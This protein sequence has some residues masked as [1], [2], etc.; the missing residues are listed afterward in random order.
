MLS[1]GARR[2]D[3]DVRDAAGDVELGRHERAVRIRLREGE[4]ALV[5]DAAVRLDA[6]PG[7]E[8]EPQHDEDREHPPVAPRTARVGRRLVGEDTQRARWR[9]GQRERGPDGA[10]RR[11]GAEGPRLVVAVALAGEQ[12][13]RRDEVDRL[14]LVAGA[15]LPRELPVDDPR[16]GR[17]PLEPLELAAVDLRS[18][19]AVTA[20][21]H[22]QRPDDVPVALVFAEVAKAVVRIEEQVLVPA[23]VD[24]FGRDRA[25]LEPDGVPRD[26]VE[27]GAFAQRDLWHVL[28]PR[29]RL[30][31]DLQRRIARVHDR[32]ARRTRDRGRVLASAQRDW[33]RARGAVEPAHRRVAQ[34]APA[35][36]QVGQRQLVELDE[37]AEEQERGV[38]GVVDRP[39]VARRG[40]EV[41]ER[42]RVRGPT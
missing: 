3:F 38:L 7:H 34:Q 9:P 4:R 40:L 39:E 29:L 13:R 19:G 22:L 11:V 10:A 36:A 18:R 5:D 16:G 23:V 24:A 14:H 2:R 31:D 33:R 42:P 1:V 20:R 8:R 30:L 28:L 41:G 25:V 35:F 21:Q 6:T 26:A 17:R 27:G 32:A 15:H 12:H 37:A